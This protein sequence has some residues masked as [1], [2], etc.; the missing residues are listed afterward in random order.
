MLSGHESHGFKRTSDDDYMFNPK[1][2][3]SFNYNNK[4]K[5]SYQGSLAGS[6][7]SGLKMDMN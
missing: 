3:G 5:Y 2:K 7:D 1:P 4:T 6:P